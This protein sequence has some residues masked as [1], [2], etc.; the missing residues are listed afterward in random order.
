MSDILAVS[1]K[2]E[3]KMDGAVFLASVLKD[4]A[5]NHSTHSIKIPKQA[6]VKDKSKCDI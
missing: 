3:S 5:A 6:I 1:G 4:G 2:G